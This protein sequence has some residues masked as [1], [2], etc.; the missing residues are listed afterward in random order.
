MVLVTEFT[1]SVQSTDGPLLFR[2]HLSRWPAEFVMAY[3]II[4][5]PIL[6]RCCLHDVGGSL[7]VQ[8]IIGKKNVPSQRGYACLWIGLSGHVLSETAKTTSACTRSFRHLCN[9]SSSMWRE[10]T[11]FTCSRIAASV[12][13]NSCRR[14]LSL[15]R[16][17][18]C[19]RQCFCRPP[20]R[21]RSEIASVCILDRMRIPNAARRMYSLSVSAALFACTTNVAFSSSV[22]RMSIREVTLRALLGLDMPCLRN[23]MGSRGAALSKMRNH[24]SE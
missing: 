19:S 20:R 2:R 16:T 5:L 14:S 22:T 7:E 17:F 8:Q 3:R 11:F 1:E 12:M 15:P 21:F 9:H 23:D 10:M 13:F 24:F 18:N 4:A 6:F